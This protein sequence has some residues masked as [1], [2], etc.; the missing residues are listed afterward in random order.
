MFVTGDKTLIWH[1]LTDLQ[2][3]ALPLL[4]QYSAI[5]P[6]LSVLQ[7]AERATPV[8]AHLFPVHLPFLVLMER[9][10]AQD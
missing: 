6:W 9:Q 2:W 5:P 8:Q 7:C 4:A 3:H 10:V 1:L